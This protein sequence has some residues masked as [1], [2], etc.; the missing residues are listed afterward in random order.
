[1]RLQK[2][3]A[4]AGVASRRKS[5]TLIT[6]GRVLVDG[7]PV[8]RL[9]TSV[10]PA[11][12]RIEVDGREVRIAAVR[13]LALH[14]PPGTLCSRGD[15]RGRP[16]V[17][18][19]I[20]RDA[21]SLFHVGRLDFMSERLLLLTNDGEVAHRLLHPSTELTRRYEVAL[22]GPAPADL[23]RALVCGV[24]LE[25][26]A[27]A[28]T[29]ASWIVPPESK[30]PVVALTLSEGRNREIRRMLAALEVRI[31]WLKRVAFGPIG[32]GDLARGETRAL[33]REE[34]ASLADVANTDIDN[35]LTHGRE[36]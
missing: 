26:G 5:E 6:A 16:T 30:Y 34:I 35:D 14:K 23:P 33:N 11:R 9:G 29:R 20:P 10:D 15:P 22:V 7:V 25:D 8:T 32:L 28:A 27:A 13:W 24:T 31:G 4:R 12:Q 17:Y 2:F 3:L 36:G 19:I 18:E 21:Q 1:V